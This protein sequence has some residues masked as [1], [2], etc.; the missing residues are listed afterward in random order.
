MTADE[1]L[2]AA[3]EAA[4][5]AS[6]FNRE[7]GITIVEAGAGSAVIAVE[8]RPEL[9]N[10][11]AALHAGVQAALL[12]TACGYAAASL[13]GNVV[14]L[15]MSLQFLSSARGERFEARAQVVRQGR[16]QLF[17]EAHLI[18]LRGGEELRAA[19]ATAVLAKPG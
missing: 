2:R 6:P 5:Q 10:H 13:A 14:T 7:A 16:A 11:A 12:D 8:A 18:A 17:V 4:N 9:M 1:T 19:S 15:Q 3:L